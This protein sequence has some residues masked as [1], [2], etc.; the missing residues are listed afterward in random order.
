MTRMCK[1]AGSSI[2]AVVGAVF[3]LVLFLWSAGGATVVSAASATAPQPA[4]I[5]GFV[6]ARTDSSLA[7]AEG[8]QAVHVVVSASTRVGGQRDSLGKIAV[9]DLVSVEGVRTAEGTL[10]AGQITVLLT[11]DGLTFSQP[12][13]PGTMWSWIAKGGLTVPVK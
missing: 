5:K 12:P 10:L 2:P 4:F 13:P 7:V 8:R 1:S 3:V 6:T 11:A 9:N